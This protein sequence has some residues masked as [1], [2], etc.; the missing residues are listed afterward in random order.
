MVIDRTDDSRNGY[1]G[2]S[3]K[4]SEDIRFRSEIGR[5][6]GCTR[7]EDTLYP[8]ILGFDGNR[9]DSVSRG[10]SR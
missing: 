10:T 3:S 4:Q 9:I 1:R 5:R 6:Y 7:L 8:S 2:S